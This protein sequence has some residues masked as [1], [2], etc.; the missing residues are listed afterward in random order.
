M[1]TWNSSVLIMNPVTKI[2]MEIDIMICKLPCDTVFQSEAI[3]TF[4]L[5]K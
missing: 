4:G 3:S 2:C 5:N 1:S